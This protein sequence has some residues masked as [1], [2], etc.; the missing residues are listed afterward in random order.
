M[1]TLRPKVKGNAANARDLSFGGKWS[2][3][4]IIPE[5]SGSDRIRD[6]QPF[7]FGGKWS[8]GAPLI[9]N[10]RKALTSP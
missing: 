2:I 6:H 10:L 3:S 7:H 5:F 9:T 8:N 4:H 1:D